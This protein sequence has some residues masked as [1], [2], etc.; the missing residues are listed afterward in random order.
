MVRLDAIRAPLFVPATRPERFAKAAAS[1]A[2]AVILDL[3]DAVA[4]GEKDAARGLIAADFTEK[5]V[6]LRVNAAGTPWHGADLAAAFDYARHVGQA[7]VLAR[8]FAAMA[9]G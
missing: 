5:P 2:D 9:R 4:E 6:I 7:P 8:R 3:E 1:E